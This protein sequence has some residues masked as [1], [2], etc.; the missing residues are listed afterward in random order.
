MVMKPPK[1]SSMDT[2]TN[3]HEVVEIWLDYCIAENFRQE[4][5]LVAFVKA[6]F[7]TKLNS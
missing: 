1:F 6:I 4:L 3:K 7:L 5:N 2:N